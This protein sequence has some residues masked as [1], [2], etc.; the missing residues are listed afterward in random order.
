MA[1]R[2]LNDLGLEGA[3][4]VV[5]GGLVREGGLLHAE[6]E[7]RLG[8]PVVVPVDPPV[9]G[10]ALAALDAAGAT[11]EACNRLRKALRAG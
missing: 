11:P 8:F 5:G 2:A 3:E 9:V 4:V 7:R 1:V 10:A 6:I